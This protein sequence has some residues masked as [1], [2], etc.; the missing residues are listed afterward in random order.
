MGNNESTTDILKAVLAQAQCP[1]IID[2][3]GINV[4]SRHIH[5]L[6]D[7]KAPIILTPHVKEFSRLSGLSVESIL[8]NPSK[9]AEEYSLA[10]TPL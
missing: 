1:V 7:C 3:D 5:Y 9:S 4:L 2:A 10:H 6:D 8:Q